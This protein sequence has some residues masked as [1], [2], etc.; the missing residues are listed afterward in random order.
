M[1]RK[2]TILISVVVNAGLLAILFIT[3]VIYDTDQKVD[4]SEF[5]TPLADQKNIPSPAEP[6]SN[7]IAAYSTGDEVDNVLKYYTSPPTSSPLVVDT[8]SDVYVPEP[9]AIQSNAAEDEDFTQEAQT[10]NQ[11]RFVEVTVKKGDMLEKIARANGT[12]VGAIKRA[13]QL[14]NERLSIGQVLKIPLKK[15]AQP[16]IIA[17][18]AKKLQVVEKKESKEKETKDNEPVY[19]VVK[20]GDNPWKIAKQFNVKS[21]DIVRLNNLDEDK[22]RNLKAGDRIRVK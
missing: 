1:T 6:P 5:V 19:Y 7:L 4:Q 15:E 10:A 9:L 2:D 11:E 17:A 8:P 14:Q 16:P 18:T 13:N 21:E 12:T 3:A 20:N 22:A